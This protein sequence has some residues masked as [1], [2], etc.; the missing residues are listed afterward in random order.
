MK[1]IIVFYDGNCNLCNSEINLYKRL[2]H[3][4]TFN[5]VDINKKAV[6]LSNHNIDFEDSL[7]YL[8]V[9]DKNGK[10]K[11]GVDAFITIWNEFRYFKILSLL[12]GMAPLKKFSGLIYNLWAKRRFKKIKNNCNI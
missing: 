6:V 2:D 3:K 5:W 7:M 11:I 4:K 9:I 10:K 12:V 8:H 1:K